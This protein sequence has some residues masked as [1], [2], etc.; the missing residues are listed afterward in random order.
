MNG[1]GDDNPSEEDALDNLLEPSEQLTS[2]ITMMKLSEPS[3]DVDV[4]ERLLLW[5]SRLEWIH[6]QLGNLKC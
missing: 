6:L 1:E 2:P 3:T 5:P 4:T